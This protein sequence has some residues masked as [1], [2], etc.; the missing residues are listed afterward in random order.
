MPATIL[1]QAGGAEGSPMSFYIMM[2]LMI[3]VFYFFMIRPQQKKAKDAKKF[4]ESLQKG[5]KVVTIGGLH[6]KVLE[7]NDTTIL[8]EVDSNVKLRFEKSAVAMDNS[9]QLN[10]ATAKA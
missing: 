6:G 9:Q 2:G 7:V 8:L 4:R 10:E 3:V 5:S 1:L